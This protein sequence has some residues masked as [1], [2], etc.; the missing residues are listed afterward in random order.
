YRTGDLARWRADG[1]LEF[2]GRA[3]Q[4]V[5][6]R[7]H[8]IE[9]GEIE[10]ALDA[11][12][13]VRESAVVAVEDGATGERRLAA[14]VVPSVSGTRLPIP[15]VTPGERE[16]ILAGHARF[17]LP[18]GTVIAHQQDHITR[19][20]YREIFED[21]AYLRHGITLEDG[22]CVVDVGSNIGM[23][24]LFAHARAPGIR[25]YSFEPIPDTFEVLR[26]NTTLLG[27][28]ARVF[29]A[30]LAEAEGEALF[31]FY[32][33]SSGLSGRYADRERDRQLARSAI[34]SWA[35]G[36]GGG[37]AAAAAGPVATAEV[38]DFLDER[39]R[40]ETFSC[41]IRTLSRVIREE[42]I[43]RID[44][45]KVDVEK[46]E[47]D[48]LLGIEDEHWPRIR[49][50]VMEVDTDDLL[51]RVTA[52]LG[53]HGFEHLVD[54]HSI[55]AP[56]DG[57]EEHVWMLYAKRRGDGQPLRRTS[58][59]DPAARR[60]PPTAAELRAY[61]AERL[62]DYLVPSLFVHLERMPR[63]PNGKTD[64]RALPRAAAPVP[65]SAAE[66][67]EPRN[68]LERAISEVWRE[69]L[70]AERVGVRDN[71]FELGG[72][73][74]G[75]AVVHQALARRLDRP[76]TVV[77]LF[78]HPTVAALAEHLS[79]GDGDSSGHAGLHDRAERQ[80]RAREA[81]QPQRRGRAGEP[82]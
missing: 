4:Q 6:V 60:T 51:E 21:E 36:E 34:E 38:D 42:G 55:T 76:V 70:G 3:D 31:T 26:V 49:Q 5:K 79:R 75:L 80:R 8:R 63:T 25:T 82:R 12:P 59:V 57:P 27:M 23:F 73:S 22:A 32:P 77:E 81:R 2:L 28:D 9:P 71:F 33:N 54:R 11:H 29:N 44:L 30:G 19:E 62:P 61:L 37:G 56:G 24:T 48:V 68:A 53:R 58:P 20:L 43:E 78:R 39:F 47:Y 10:A 41:P 7:G 18:D 40:A 66:H 65:S 50:V 13:G 45:L 52:L 14:Y 46:S 17:R 1:I 64:R 72:T 74:L 67:V 15:T 16:Q 69:V 35:R